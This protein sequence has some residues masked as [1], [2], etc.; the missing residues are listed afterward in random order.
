ME[1]RPWRRIEGGVSLTV[2]LT[3]KSS[4]ECIEGLRTDDAGATQLAA[5]VRAAPDKGAANAALERLVAGWLGAAPSTVTITAGHTSRIKTVAVAGD[6]TALLR[7]LEDRLAG[8]LA[9]G[10]GR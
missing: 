8:P 9:A 7:L 4:R 6:T 5:R 10:S 3:P 2:R 1:N